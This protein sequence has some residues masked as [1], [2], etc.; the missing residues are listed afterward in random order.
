MCLFKALVA[1]PLEAK[2]KP[3]ADRITSE[4]VVSTCSV[5][6]CVSVCFVDSCSLTTSAALT[7]V[8]ASL[9]LFTTGFVLVS[10]TPR[11]SLYG[12]TTL[13]GC[14]CSVTTGASSVLLDSC[15]VVAS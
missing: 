15:S 1:A 9:V 10:L 2:A 7:S 8:L 6:C 13:A 3:L 12:L 4:V 14:A 11:L 5:S